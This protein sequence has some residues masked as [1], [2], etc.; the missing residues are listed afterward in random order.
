MSRLDNWC[1]FQS[2]ARSL[3]VV[4][5]D[6]QCT[7]DRSLIRRLQKEEPPD[8][9]A[10]APYKAPLV[11][12]K[13]AIARSKFFPTP[14][15]GLQVLRLAA[16]TSMWTPKDPKGQDPLRSRKTKRDDSVMAT[17]NSSIVSKR[18]VERLYYPEPHLYRYFV[19]KPLRRS[20][21][22]NRKSWMLQ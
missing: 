10:E 18:S 16:K 3:C 6:V 17:N 15:Y 14:F 7:L 20:P 13:K 1:L 9:I 5:L 22:I 2:V 12:P 11:A 8:S 19:K 21:L 4:V